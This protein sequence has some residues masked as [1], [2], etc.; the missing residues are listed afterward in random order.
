MTVRVH[1]FSLVIMALVAPAAAQPSASVPLDTYVGGRVVT[2]AAGG[3]TTYTYSWP[4]VYFEAQ[5]MG[6]AV[7]AKVNDSEDNLYLYVDGVHKL[8]LTRPGRTTVSLKELG[9]GRHVV[10]LEKASETQSAT[11]RFEGFYVASTGQALPA[12][13]Y[14]RR[15]EFI[16]DSFTVGYG[17]TARGRVCTVD[18]VR[19]TTDTSEAFAPMTAK[20][21]GAAYRI[22][23]NS[24]HGI[25]RNYANMDPGN[26]LPVI[27]NYALF[28]KSMPAA[29]EGWTPEVVVV[30]LGT[31]D[32]STS[33]ADGEPWKTREDLRADFVRGYVAFVTTLHAKWPEARIILM[34]STEFEREIIDAV[35]VAADTL[36]GAGIADLEVISFSDLDY[37]ACDGH[38]SLKDEQLLSHL[39]ID[40]ISLLPKF[41]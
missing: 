32:F 30:G 39:L 5:F 7:D 40:R 27:Y 17:N 26:T 36:K 4:G 29:D 12:P 8:T 38:P 2:G 25:V 35:N 6:D 11:G 24:G 21:F 31:N 22:N 23:A 1:F 10:R 33:L 20:H 14:D 19:D 15:I 13:I 37:M 41:K 18:D 16:G 34:A 9:P 3:Q 28:D